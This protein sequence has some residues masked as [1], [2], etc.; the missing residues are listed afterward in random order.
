VLALPTVRNIAPLVEEEPSDP[1]E[2]ILASLR[3]NWM[4]LPITYNT[5]PTNYTGHPALAVPCGKVD[6][7]PISLQLIGNFLADPLLLRAAYAF[8]RAAD[9]EAVI[10]VG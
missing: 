10:G 3:R 2:A 8:Q 9:W 6:G 1:A 4:M 7:M 5:K